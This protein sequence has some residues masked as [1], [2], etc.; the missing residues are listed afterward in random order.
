MDH[1]YRRDISLADTDLEQLLGADAAE[2]ETDER[3]LEYFLET[4]AFKAVTDLDR[5]LRV[6]V[7]SKG[8]GKS[9]IFRIAALEDRGAGRL[10]IDV[11][12]DDLTDVAQGTLNYLQMVSAWKK[13]LAAVIIEKSLK[14]LGDGDEKFLGKAKKATGHVL[15]VIVKSLGDEQK[16]YKLDAARTEAAAAFMANRELTLYLDD[17][18]RGWT[19]SPSDAARY[20][21]MFDAIRDLQREN[22]TLR[23]RVGLRTDLYTL[24]RSTDTSSDKWQSSV[25]HHAW[26]NHETFVLLVKRIVTYFNGEQDYEE[27][28]LRPQQSSAHLLNP[29]LDSHFKGK[30]LWHRKPMYNVIMSFARRRPRDL[31]VLL[32]IAGRRAKDQSH[33]VIQ[34]QDLEDSFARFSEGRLTDTVNEFGLE[35]PGLGKFLM[36][37]KPSKVERTA[38][39]SYLLSTDAMLMRVKQALDHAPLRF[40]D[41]RSATP[42]AVLAFLYRIDFLQARK[43]A[44]D[45][46][47]D[48]KYFDQNQLLTPDKIDLGYDWEIHLAFRWV[49]QPDDAADVFA[50]VPPDSTD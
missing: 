49:L 20:G 5:K 41:G 44:T 16:G 38:A 4:P 23:V 17:L 36:A 12:P 9:A 46:S 2:D 33:S 25:I 43:T 45:D 10:P 31:V 32:N 39:K 1:E 6:V 42:M 48:R 21:A 40:A 14:A 26:S 50:F 7:G 15:D 28:L 35:A 34:T 3:L 13:G 18:D 37:M 19:G 29:I 47:V 24:I 30:G 27:L 11:R 22:P 8:T